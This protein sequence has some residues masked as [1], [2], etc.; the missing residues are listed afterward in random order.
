MCIR[1]SPRKDVEAVAA[2]AVRRQLADPVFQHQ[3]RSLV[4][5]EV[6]A[7][8]GLFEHPLVKVALAVVRELLLSLINI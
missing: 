6:A 4:D 8:Q 7:V 5:G 1:D 2:A 3:G